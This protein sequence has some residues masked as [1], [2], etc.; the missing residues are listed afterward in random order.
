MIGF[1]DIIRHLIRG[2]PES[3][4]NVELRSAGFSRFLEK[5]P[6]FILFYLRQFSKEAQKGIYSNKIIEHA[7][8]VVFRDVLPFIWARRIRVFACR[9]RIAMFR[10]GESFRISTDQPW[11]SFF[12]G[13]MA[14][15]FRLKPSSS[16]SHT[17]QATWCPHFPDS[18]H[19]PPS[20][21]AANRRSIRHRQYSSCRVPPVYARGSSSRAIS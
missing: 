7:H 4:F 6:M 13:W 12:L 16:S 1:C 11:I 3:S 9:R 20:W 17:Q 21:F 19:H 14:P 15:K 2:L 18:I 10:S 8:T 5:H